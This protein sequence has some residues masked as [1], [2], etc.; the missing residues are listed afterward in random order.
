MSGFQG[1]ADAL[2]QFVPRPEIANSGHC[3]AS[4]D[5]AVYCSKIGLLDTSVNLTCH[6]PPK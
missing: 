3:A 6:H 5:E 4:I 1:E 2:A